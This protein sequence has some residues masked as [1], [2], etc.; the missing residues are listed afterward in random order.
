MFFFIMIRR[1]PRSTRTDTLFPYTTLFRSVHRRA[2]RVDAA[3]ERIDRLLAADLPGDR[4]QQALLRR[5]QDLRAGDHK[6]EGAGAEGDLSVAPLAAAVDVECRTLVDDA[7]DHWE[8]EDAHRRGAAVV[9]GWVD[10]RQGFTRQLDE[11]E[12]SPTHDPAP[13]VQPRGL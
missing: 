1:P 2:R 9:G 8:T 12:G 6:G 5:A 3:V 4:G 13:D 11:G 7:G 10:L